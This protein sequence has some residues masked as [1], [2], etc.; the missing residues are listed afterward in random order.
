MRSSAII[1][2]QHPNH[3]TPYLARMET[4]CIDTVLGELYEVV[5]TP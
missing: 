1:L 4:E 2:S 5:A 3:L